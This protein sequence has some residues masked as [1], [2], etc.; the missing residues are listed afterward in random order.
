MTPVQRRRAIMAEWHAAQGER[1]AAGV[2]EVLRALEQLARLKMH[3][4]PEHGRLRLTAKD[5]RLAQHIAISQRR[6][7]EHKGSEPPAD[8]EVWWSQISEIAARWG[9]PTRREDWEREKTAGVIDHD[10]VDSAP[11]YSATEAV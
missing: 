2:P 10:E 11:R 7:I 8:V 6:R 4:V 5:L 3:T 9:I 1:G